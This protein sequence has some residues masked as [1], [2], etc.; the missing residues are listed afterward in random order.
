MIKQIEVSTWDLFVKDLEKATAQGYTHFV[1][2]D[3]NSEIYQ[4]MLEAV[5]LKP[6]TIVADYTI[7]QQYLND[8]RYFG[9]PE[10][11]FNDWMDNL[12]HFPNIIF[13]IET[14][15]K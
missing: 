13:H 3:Q 14:T 12:N 6:V 1:Y 2:I 11:T 10:I 9:K 5:T 15:Q 7:N 8:C 4:S